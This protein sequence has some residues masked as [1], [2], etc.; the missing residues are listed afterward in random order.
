MSVLD[1]MY[2]CVSRT[3][4]AG[5]LLTNGWPRTMP[6]FRWNGKDVSV[7]SAEDDTVSLPVV[8]FIVFMIFH[9]AA[10]VKVRSQVLNFSPERFY[11]TALQFSQ[12]AFSQVS[13]PSVQGLVILICSSIFSPGQVKLWTLVHLALSHCVELGIHREPQD[14]GEFD[15]AEIQIRR[16]VFWI[17]YSLDR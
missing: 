1:A 10:V 9:I 12:G 14:D 13:L 16:F 6:S 2:V 3:R 8:G 4:D 17:V 5:D 15:S 11:Q 7:E